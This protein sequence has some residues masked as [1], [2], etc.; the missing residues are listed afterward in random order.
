MSR[1]LPC[2]LLL[3]G[4]SSGALDARATTFTVTRTD[5]PSPDDCLPGDC[6]LREATLAANANDPAAGT[7]RIQLAAASYTLVRGALT[8]TQ[9]LELVGSGSAATHVTTDVELFA[10]QHDHTLSVRGLSMQTTVSNVLTMGDDGHLV[11]DDVSVPVGGG[12]V[13]SYGTGTSL[14]VRDSD[15]RDTLRCNQST[16]PCTVVDSSLLNFYVVPASGGPTVLIQRSIVDGDLDPGATPAPAVVLHAGTTAIQ[17][18]TITHTAA[19]R[20][21]DN[22]GQQVSLLRV[23]YVDN[24]GPV[25]TDI[26]AD[27]SIAD[28]E[29]RD[30]VGRALRVDGD[31][32]WIVRGSSFIDNQVDDSAGGAIVVQGGASVHIENSTFSGNSFS[33]AAAGNGARGAA[34][35]YHGDNGSVSVVLRHVTIVPPTVMPFGID[36][37]AIGG[38]DGASV[39]VDVSNSI[40]R[41]SCRFDGGALRN[42]AGNI[43]SPGDTCG[44]DGSSQVSV[45]P[46]DVAL[47]TLG[48]HGGP[49]PTYEPAGTSVAVDAGGAPQCLE[50]DQRGY[51]RPAGSGCDAGAVEVDAIDDVIFADGFDQA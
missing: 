39:D 9:D 21:L 28:S 42:H 46:A 50:F 34:I 35:G 8:C 51:L 49:T 6:S 32:N 15:L 26:D 2:L 43:E 47:G 20:I 5:D 3:I 41:G 14:E 23:H 1:P 29:F 12:S 37:T 24:S 22:P 25:S 13:Q 30:N 4:L 7:D 33:T 10:N 40:V 38:F 16:G 31:A 17:D 27:V 48:D 19:L 45:P 44:F 36:G 18:S 11:L